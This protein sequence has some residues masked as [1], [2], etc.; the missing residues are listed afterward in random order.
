[1]AEPHQQFEVGAPLLVLGTVW[2][3]AGPVL[4]ALKML[5]QLRDRVVGIGQK[6]QLSREQRAILFWSDWV[7]LWAGVLVFLGLLTGAVLAGAAYLRA[8]K[9]QPVGFTVF[10]YLTAAL[11]SLTFVGFLIGGF[12]DIGIMLKAIRTDTPSEQ[13]PPLSPGRR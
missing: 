3:F 1:M 4:T 8:T 13:P 2:L 7:F 6:H 11:P 10:C 12:L 5:N 9:E